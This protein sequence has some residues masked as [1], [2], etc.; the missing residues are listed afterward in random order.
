MEYRCV[1]TSLE[2]FI[3]QLAV[4]YIAHGYYFFVSGFVPEGKDPESVDR[5]LLEKYGIRLSK[6][7]RHRRKAIGQASV[8]YLRFERFFVL[9]ATHGKHPFFWEEKDGGEGGRIKDVRRTPIRFAG[10]SISSRRRAGAGQQL[11]AHV[12]IDQTSYLEVRDTLVDLGTKRSREWAEFQFRTFPFEA[13]APVRRQVLSI[14]N[15]VN[16][17]R[18]IANL[19]ALD[20][21]C[22]KLRR[23]PIKPF[24]ETSSTSEP[25]AA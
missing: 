12:R 5:K 24:E 15:R 19:E 13:Y 10:Y 8:Q 4:A 11:V 20:R 1:A 7:A 3:Q 14:F 18:K 2:G 6:F 21:S 16:R 9:I 17:R 25:V 22:L 23:R